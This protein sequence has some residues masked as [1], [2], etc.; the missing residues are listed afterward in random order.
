MFPLCAICKR[1]PATA[2]VPVHVLGEVQH[3]PQCDGCHEGHLAGLE[4]IRRLHV[5]EWIYAITLQPPWSFAMAAGL[6]AWETRGWQPQAVPKGSLVAVTTS[7][8][9]DPGSQ[10]FALRHGDLVRPALDAFGATLD[11]KTWPAGVALSVHRYGGS[12]RT[13]A[14]RPHLEEQ[15]LALGNYADGRYGIHLPLVC[16]L[17]VPVAVRGALNIWQWRVPPEVRALLPLQAREPA[18]NAPRSGN[19][20]TPAASGSGQGVL[21]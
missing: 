1:V 14:L 4:L 10:S 20:S 17:P 9:V 18:G 11:A 2:L 16:R 21:L 8:K 7:A 5:P 19:V 12:E 6:K 3:V 15:D 13:E